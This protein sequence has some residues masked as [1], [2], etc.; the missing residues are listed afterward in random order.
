VGAVIGLTIRKLNQNPKP[1]TE[2][3]IA[4]IT[5]KQEDVYRIFW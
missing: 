3:T 1:I 2:H 5:S 4:N